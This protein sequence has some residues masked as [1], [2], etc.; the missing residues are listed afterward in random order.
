MRPQPIA[1]MTSEEMHAEIRE[2]LRKANHN[3]D[4]AEVLLA[5]TFVFATAAIL[6]ALVR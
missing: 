3:L 5:L 1:T 2:N 4:I 6:I